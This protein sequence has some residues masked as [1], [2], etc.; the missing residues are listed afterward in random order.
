VPAFTAPWIRRGMWLYPLLMAPLAVATLKVALTGGDDVSLCFK[1]LAVW[2]LSCLTMV[3]TQLHAPDHPLEFLAG[4]A[5]A[6]ILHFVI[7][8]LQAYS[9]TGGV[10]PLVGLEVNPSFLCVQGNAG[11]GAS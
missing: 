8:L 10:F 1:S 3:A 9:F 7:G 2:G 6:T 5:I 4:I 11:A